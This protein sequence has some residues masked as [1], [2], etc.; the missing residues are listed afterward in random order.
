VT[1]ADTIDPDTV[2]LVRSPDYD[3]S[4]VYCVLATV[5]GGEVLV[6][7]LRRLDRRWTDYVREF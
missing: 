2:H 6:D 3:I 7:S 4:G 1:P 5:N